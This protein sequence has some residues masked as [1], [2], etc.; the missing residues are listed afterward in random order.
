MKKLLTLLILLILALA[1]AGFYWF[2]WR[3]N[4]I[5]KNCNIEAKAR[6]IETIKKFNLNAK[7]ILPSGIFPEEFYIPEEQNAYYEECIR[8][9]GLVK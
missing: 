5:V 6:A 4:Q 1:G 9:H 2:G 7:E 3:P 8:E